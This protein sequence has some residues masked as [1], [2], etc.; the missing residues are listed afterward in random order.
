[1]PSSTSDAGSS[2]S[3]WITVPAIIVI[4]VW[5]LLSATAATTLLVILVLF[6]SSSSISLS[7]MRRLRIYTSQT[8][9]AEEKLDL[10][11]D[12][13]QLDLEDGTLEPHMLTLC[14]ILSSELP[15]C[16]IFP[17]D[18]AAFKNSMNSYW[19]QQEREV[20]PACVLRPRD[21]RQLS[22]AVKTLKREYDE[23]K[24]R[25]GNNHAAGLFAIRSGGHSPIPGAASIKGGVMIDLR[26]FCEVTPS[27]DGL[28]VVIG[29]GA[30]W[31]NVSQVLDE[32]G[33]AVVGG[34]NSAVGV[35]GLI[36]G[37]QASPPFPTCL[38]KS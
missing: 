14:K 27:E 26:H 7:L 16:V 34:R 8:I 1:M 19:A 25:A 11:R 13:D 33:L 10:I 32:K 30:R 38:F 28:S 23:Q 29:S 35:G 3:R 17:R 24:N 15:D 18:T 36:L 37:G 21:T 20:S 2:S 6:I 4:L 31:M 22:A 5:Q 12:G 9:Q